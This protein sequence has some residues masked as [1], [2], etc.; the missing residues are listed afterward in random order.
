MRWSQSQAER[1]LECLTR[2]LADLGLEPKAAKT[3][4]VS[5]QPGGGGFDFLGFHHRLVRSRGD[6]G[7][8]KVTFLA[9]WPSDRAMR[10]ARDRIR[11]ITDRSRL[12]LPPQVI[13]ERLNAFLRGW[14]GYF[15]FGHS[16][17][18]LSMIRRFAQERL[19]RFVRARHKRSMGF[20]WRVLSRS[21]P[22]DL[23]LISLY[24]IS[25]K[26]GKTWREKP[27]A[28]GERRR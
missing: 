16:A 23:G 24:G 8:R 18:H 17:R 21:R 9:R 13:V 25:P 19:A 20:G 12:L 1:A 2:L 4:I 22:V 26:A 10:H 11:E 27:N 14:A 6:R 5:L 15:R 7:R 3:R 28:G